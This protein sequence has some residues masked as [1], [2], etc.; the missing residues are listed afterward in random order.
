MS[1]ATLAATTHS[2]LANAQQQ[3]KTL[4]QPQGTQ[5][6]TTNATNMTKQTALSDF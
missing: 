4:M 3:I 6:M 1:V 2:G 5:S